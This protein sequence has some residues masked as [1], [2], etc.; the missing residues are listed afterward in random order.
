MGEAKR[1]KALNPNYGNRNTSANDYTRFKNKNQVGVT[2]FKFNGVVY[3]YDNTQQHYINIASK[4]SRYSEF[5]NIIDAAIEDLKNKPDGKWVFVRP[6]EGWIN[7]PICLVEVLGI[8]V[9]DETAGELLNFN[10]PTKVHYCVI[11]NDRVK[12]KSL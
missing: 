8:S 11:E 7:I 2:F 3:N 5:K 10:A 12:V 1:R 9:F 6:K 4:S